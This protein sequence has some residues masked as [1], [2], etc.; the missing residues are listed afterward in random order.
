MIKT[1][2]KDPLSWA[3]TNSC[4]L[5]SHFSVNEFFCCCFSCS[6]R[7]KRRKVFFW[8]TIISWGLFSLCLLCTIFLL[9]SF[10]CKKKPQ[11][12]LSTSILSRSVKQCGACF[13]FVWRKWKCSSRSPHPSYSDSLTFCT[14]VGYR[15][16]IIFLG[17]W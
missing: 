1:I 12:P 17:W 15:V 7:K 13:F 4:W 9:L 5:Y 3:S 10:K 2:K 16:K 8:S 6:K 14:L 11:N